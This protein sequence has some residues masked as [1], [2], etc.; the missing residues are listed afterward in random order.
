[1]PRRFWLLVTIGALGCGAE[2]PSAA[3]PAPSSATK[4]SD[5]KPTAFRPDACGGLMGSVTWTGP[6]PVVPDV[7][8][9]R[10]RPDGTGY[11]SRTLPH[12]YAPAVE[13]TTFAL[14]GAV[15]F[16]RN[17]D[18]ARAKPWDLPPVRVEFRDGQIVVAQGDRGPGRVGFVHKGAAVNFRSVEPV[19]NVLRG[20]GSAFF[21]LPFPDH[22]KPLERTFDAPGRVA[23]TSAAGFHWQAADLFVCEHPYY[24]V[25]GADGRFE[26]TQVPEG[27]YDLCVWHPN[28]NTTSHERNPETGL[29]QRVVYAPP[30]ES[31]RSVTVSPGRTAFAPMN[32]SLPK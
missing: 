2:P 7:T 27:T 15:V 30:L 11:D 19:F 10:P 23:L 3:G 21:A 9:I 31:V 25:S 17:V 8:D 32:L 13:R 18:A 5:E 6:I 4:P 26:F 16:L 12:P 22:D 14:R 28:W 29:I 24:A 1:M 20:R